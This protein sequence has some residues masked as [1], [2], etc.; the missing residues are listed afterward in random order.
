[1][2]TG[3]R[4]PGTLVVAG[5][6]DSLTYGWMVRRGFFDRAVDALSGRFPQAKIDRINAGVPG[7]TAP[8]GFLRAATVLASKPDAIAIQFGLN[9]CYA[10][11]SPGEYDAAVRRIAD[12]AVRAGAL[13]ILVTSCPTDL[14]GGPE[15][16]DPY[17]GALRALAAERSLPLADADAAWRALPAD[18]ASELYLD[19]GVHPSD[20]GHA[21][22]ADVLA[23]TLAALL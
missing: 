1:M 5:L 10:G 19:D 20:E 17:Y 12:L 22:M 21:F 7:D 6:G 15:A 23:A 13:P 3:T 9:D 2:E 16:M 18:R 14:P 11:V 4:R 8:G